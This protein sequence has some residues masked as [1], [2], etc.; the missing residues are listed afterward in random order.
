M[1]QLIGILG[2]GVLAALSAGSHAE[3]LSCEAFSYER[4]IE[5]QDRINRYLHS[6]VVPNMLNCWEALAS[7][8]TVS[9]AFKFRRD[10]DEWSAGD[11][12][13]LASTLDEGQDEIA[14]HCLQEA[15]RETSFP[16]TE[17]DGEVSELRVN[18]TFP[19]PWPTSA[20]EFVGLAVDT[21]GVGC[22]PESPP[23]C[24]DCVKPLGQPTICKKVCVGYAECKTDSDGTGCSMMG[25]CV[26]GSAFGNVGGFK[27]YRSARAQ[28]P[29]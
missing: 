2:V 6:A 15:V 13:L 12:N 3:E 10:A 11:S 9:V 21:G 7:R 22:G 16:A 28:L 8:G 14:L 23:A 27:I 29:W 17:A 24:F 20:E 26:T 25:N 4:V 1:K 5:K 19:V 18:W